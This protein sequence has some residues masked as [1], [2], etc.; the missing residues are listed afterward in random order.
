MIYK[1]LRIMVLNVKYGLK[2]FSI[3]TKLKWSLI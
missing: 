2:N 3:F 1:M